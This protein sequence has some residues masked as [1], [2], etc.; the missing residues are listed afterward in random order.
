MVQWEG[1]AVGELGGKYIAAG[2]V[3]EIAEARDGEL[4]CAGDFVRVG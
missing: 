2:I 4:E 1:E 3:V